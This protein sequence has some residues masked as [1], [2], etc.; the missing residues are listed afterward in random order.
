[1]QQP[2]WI[3]PTDYIFLPHLPINIYCICS[4]GIHIIVVPSKSTTYIPAHSQDHVCKSSEP[5]T[6]ALHNH[7]IP[8][9]VTL[10]GIR[11]PDNL[12][13]KPHS[14]SKITESKWM[15]KNNTTSPEPGQKKRL[16]RI[17]NPCTFYLHSFTQ[18]KQQQ[19]FDSPSAT[20]RNPKQRLTLHSCHRT[21]DNS[22]ESSINTSCKE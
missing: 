11:W 4:P 8:R 17:F 14:D 16:S 20:F 12:C 6:A 18:R 9:G 22:K 15:P 19:N 21:C 13:G 3:P 7:P 2:S 10:P 1:M 5:L